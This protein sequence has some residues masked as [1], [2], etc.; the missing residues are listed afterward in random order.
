MT[1]VELIAKARQVAAEMRESWN[2]SGDQEIGRLISEL[3][4]RLEAATV[5]NADLIAACRSADAKFAEIYA[6]R[7]GAMPEAV[8]A[9]KATIRKATATVPS[10]PATVLPSDAEPADPPR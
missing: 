1:T 2:T 6:S 4:D 8:L 5:A 9:V 7:T 10:P 3:A